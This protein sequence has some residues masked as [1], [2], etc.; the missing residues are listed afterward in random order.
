MFIRGIVRINSVKKQLITG[1]VPTRSV[2]L[3]LGFKLFDDAVK[4][5]R[6]K[7]ICHFLLQTPVARDLE[8]LLFQLVLCHQ[9]GPS[10]NRR[11]DSRTVSLKFSDHFPWFPIGKSSAARR[12]PTSSW[13]H[14]ATA[15]RRAANRFERA[16]L[17]R[18]A[19]LDHGVIEQFEH[20][21]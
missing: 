4:Q 1:P 21:P 7:R 6:S 10:T 15:A 8:F 17:Q 3:Q 11:G 20:Q 5:T 2:P 14:E 9:T 12:A 16:G 13:R 18:R 19:S